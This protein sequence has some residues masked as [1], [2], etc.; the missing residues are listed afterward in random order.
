MAQLIYLLDVPYL[1]FDILRIGYSG[2]DFP[3]KSKVKWDQ[4]Y[5]LQAGL[6]FNLR[7]SGFYSPR[8]TVREDELFQLLGCEG[9]PYMFVH[10]D[11]SRR[12][13]INDSFLP[14]S[15][16]RRSESEFFLSLDI[17]DSNL[18]KLTCCSADSISILTCRNMINEMLHSISVS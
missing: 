3:S 16:R 8:N 7:W 18:S 15:I 2:E 12:F 9:E 4:N 10:E 6:D 17:A 13:L 14:G 1:G 11:E 5:Y